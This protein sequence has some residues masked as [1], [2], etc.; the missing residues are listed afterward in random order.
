MRFG[1]I[2]CEFEPT[3]LMWGDTLDV[4]YL[5]FVL[6]NVSIDT[7][8]I[9]LAEFGFQSQTGHELHLFHCS[10][11]KNGLISF[12]NKNR[13]EWHVSKSDIERFKERLYALARASHGHQYL[14]S[15]GD[16]VT[17]KVSLNE[18]PSDYLI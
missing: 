9:S 5:A 8:P 18:Y 17:L 1:F 16:E 10:Q 11:G 15:D 6:E 14:E 3:L 4:R 2:D 13:F 12:P 7:P